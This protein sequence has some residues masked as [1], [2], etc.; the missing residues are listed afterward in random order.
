MKSNYVIGGI[1]ILAIA[2]LLI[3]PHFIAQTPSPVATTTETTLKGMQTTPAPWQPEITNLRERLQ[4]LGLPALSEEGTV[5][6]IHQHL[7]IFVHGKVVPVPADIGI[8][9]AAQFISDVHTH[10]ATGIIHI[11]SPDNQ[12]FTLGQFFDIWG[13]QFSA[14]TLGGYVADSTNTLKV[15]VNGK[16]VTGDPR[17]VVLSPHQEIVVVFGSAHE[18]PKTI[19]TSF[20]FD[21]GL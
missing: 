3:A 17:A 18:A 16:E 5:L 20:V 13:V 2:L 14:T 15:Y 1:I 11:E 9:E 6:H 8:N 7:D 12:T 4:V 19:P 10:D 21:P